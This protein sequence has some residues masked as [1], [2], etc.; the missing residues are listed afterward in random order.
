MVEL[1]FEEK[2]GVGVLQNPQMIDLSFY[3]EICLIIPKRFNIIELNKVKQFIATDG[4]VKIKVKDLIKGT[5][6]LRA[7]NSNSILPLQP[8]MVTNVNDKLQ[9]QLAT[10]L[11]V[12]ES[13]KE[14]RS[15]IVE[16]NKFL[17]VVKALDLKN[18]VKS[19]GRLI[20]VS[21]NLQERVADIEKNYDPTIL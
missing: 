5:N 13:I 14:L 20:D 4:R 9:C 19:V 8:I 12:L 21:N 2:N 18:V 7:I 15:A 6:T 3:S 17:D 10:S 16:I 11:D 1:I